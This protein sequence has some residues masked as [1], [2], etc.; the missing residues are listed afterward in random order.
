MAQNPLAR[1][2]SWFHK[3]W[4]RRAPR[5]M[6][7]ERKRGY[8]GI[9]GFP[10]A[11]R[12]LQLQKAPDPQGL[13]QTTCL[14]YPTRIRDANPDVR[15]EFWQPVAIA[16]VRCHSFPLP[17]IPYRRLVAG[18]APMQLRFHWFPLILGTFTSLPFV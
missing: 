14:A 7:G 2:W 10:P 5:A 8:R 12:L 13:K 6:G 1:E 9:P 3:S 16:Y 4:K 17:P 11:L 18:S 15:P